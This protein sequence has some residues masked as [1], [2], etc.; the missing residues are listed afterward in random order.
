MSRLDTA[1]WLLNQSCIGM[2]FLV[3]GCAWIPAG[4]KPAEFIEAP[5]MEHT[6]SDS[7]HNELAASSPQW[8]A[9]R[10]WLEFGSAELNNL[11]TIALKNSTGLKVA[12]ARIRQ[13]QAL[14]RVEGAR[15]LPF[16]DAE[17]ELAN[18]RIS[19]NG[20]FAVLNR[21]EA[22][23][24]NILFGR[25]NPFNFR[26]EFDFWGKNRAAL[27]AALGE[28]SAEKAE[29]AEVW[30]QLTGAIARSY[31][32]GVALRQQLDLIHDIVELHRELLQLAET[33]FRLGLDS[34]DPVKQ[35]KVDLELANKREAG[36]RDQLDLQRNLLARLIGNGPDSTQSLFTD[37]D[38][39]DIPKDLRLPA[40][41]PL[42]L[43]AHR[44]DLA[45]A[46]YRAEAA[47]QRVKVGKASFLPTIDLTAFA[48]LN[49]LRLTKGA[50]SLANI[51][52]SGSS[53]SYGIA[54]GLR[55][56]WFEGG[57]LR[58]E[59]S[60]QRAEY[61]GA[62]ELYNDTLLHAIQEVA[63]SLSSWKESRSILEA[64]NRLLSSQRQ[65]EELAADRLRL[66]LDDRRAM[67]GRHDV[68]LDQEYALKTLEA[69]HLVAMVDLIEAL[70]GG[71]S[72]DLKI[73][74][75]LIKHKPE[76]PEGFDLYKWLIF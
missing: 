65:N 55:L 61:D 68:V 64:Q 16:L 31:F 12:A 52:F 10:W 30:L 37:R 6:L 63:D 23:G 49:A 73:V 20:V 38:Q 7:D 48:G 35:A 27:E 40:K 19:E 9:E 4:D 74:Q 32:R 51:L 22:A 41:L 57:R 76:H 28:A 11:M 66:G 34:A 33:R 69:D 46:L 47:A 45:V 59:L 25:V 56:P 71:Y 70:G 26:Y 54:P 8:P 42:E 21:K 43:L 18:E 14:A 67:L 17:V 39:G 62:V 13:A 58:A 53:F 2:M 60:V 72:N 1:R 15:L 44:P 5:S 29:H 3:S 36:T 50:S 24:A 75:Q